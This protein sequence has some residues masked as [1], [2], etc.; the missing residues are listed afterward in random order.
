[1]KKR[2]FIVASIYQL[3]NAINIAEQTSGNMVS[4]LVIFKIG[5][6]F[7]D[8]V[9]L[10][11]LKCVFRNIFVVNIDIKKN[12]FKKLLYCFKFAF[13][14]LNKYSIDG[15]YDTVCLA[16]TEIFSRICAVKFVKKTGNFMLYE[17]G[18]A[19]Y[20]SVLNKES[21]LYSDL[22]LRM[23]FGKSILKNSE[24]LFVYEPEAVRN[25]SYNIR[26][27]RINKINR[28]GKLNYSIFFKVKPFKIFTKFVF[29]NAWFDNEEEYALQ[30]YLCKIL[31]NTVGM[32]NVT[33]KSHP[34][35]LTR[36]VNRNE[37][38][39]IDSYCPF[40]VANYYENWSNV[41]FVSVISSAC[42]TPKIIYGDAPKII[43]L[44]S[45][46]QDKFNLWDNIDETMEIFLQLYGD[47]EKFAIPHT[48]DEYINILNLWR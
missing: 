35:E 15:R 20:Y 43:Y 6:N 12:R 42:I 41:I 16:G 8:Y 47:S 39:Y 22:M 23:L 10:D 24:G 45:F 34:N 25:N 21:K 7:V 5:N 4:D 11:E 44:Y 13:F 17:D 14:E 38:N 9:N 19:S 37:G 29:L 18:I 33:I 26:C 3:F 30:S 1:M 31:I 28:T 46:F 27:Y 48:V 2:M 36:D 40:E 32:E